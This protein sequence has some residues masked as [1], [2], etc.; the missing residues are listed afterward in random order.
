MDFLPKPRNCGCPCHTEPGVMHVA[1]CCDAP[2]YQES[3]D[4]DSLTT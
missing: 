3:S 1:A 2:P 4:E